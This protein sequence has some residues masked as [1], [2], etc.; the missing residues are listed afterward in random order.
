MNLATA[1]QRGTFLSCPESADT[2]GIFRRFLVS[3]ETK[4]AFFIFPKMMNFANYFA[5]LFF[6]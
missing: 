6:C 1:G 2:K 5:I 4:N 3:V